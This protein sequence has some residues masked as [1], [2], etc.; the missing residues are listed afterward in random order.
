MRISGSG[1]QGVPPVLLLA[2]LLVAVIPAALLAAEYSPEAEGERF[3][4]VIGIDEYQA[5]GKLTVCRNDARVLARVLIE[6]GGYAEGRVVLMTDDATEPQNRPTLATM[7]RRIEQV[8]GLAGKDDTVL[9]YFSGHGITKDGQ[10]YLVPMDGDADSAIPLASVREA[11]AKSKAASKVLILDACHAGS[12]VK[13]VGG[14]APSLVADVPGLVMLLSSAAD[15][16]SYPDENG[17]RSVFS[18]YLAEGLSGAA[19]GDADET[20]TVAELGAFV[21]RSMKN[22][23]LATGKTQTPFF[24]PERLPALVVTRVIKRVPPPP[25]LP[26][27]R[28]PV[29]SPPMPVK[30][31]PGPVPT[32][33]VSWPYEDSWQPPPGSVQKGK[34]DARKEAVTGRKYYLY[35]PS[36]YDPARAYP[37]VVSAHGAGLFDGAKKDRDRWI[38]V[39]ERYGLLVCCPEFESP[40]TPFLRLKAGEVAPE[41]IR[42]EKASLAIIEEVKVRFHVNRD[43][44]LMTGFGKGAYAAHFI[45]IRH[46]DIF[47]AV[48]GRCGDFSEHLVSNDFAHRARH[49]HVYT[50]FGERDLPGVDEMNRNAN[51]YHTVRG[52]RNFVIRRLRGGHDSNEAEAAR[53]F[54]NMVNHWP[55]TRIEATPTSGKAPLSVMFRARVRDADT[56]DG[57][58]DSVLWNL[59]DGAVSGHPE[60]VHTYVSPGLYNVF[61][62]VVDLDGHHEYAQQW[63]VVE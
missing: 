60:L 58:V 6:T 50:F 61:L 22:W 42:D 24:Y 30:P 54:K 33:K 4:V 53:Y 34:I 57:Q 40:K 46:P 18:K 62:T 56:P 37:L 10:G 44:V 17:T 26:P 14:I 2:P 48:V 52:F 45:G 25:L 8:A 32:G 7:K 55:T 3:A 27:P 51:F 16:V 47:R 39:A 35:V 5:L 38:E 49:M 59:G 28:R 20:V 36:N 13:G 29:R 12:A 11:L 19:D 23:S 21:N 41:L 15:Q 1:H 9:V 31:P 63:I 43:A